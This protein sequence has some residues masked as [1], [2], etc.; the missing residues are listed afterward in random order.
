MRSLTARGPFDSLI[1]HWDLTLD[2]EDYFFILVWVVDVD[3]G[4]GLF[5][6]FN[7]LIII[8]HKVCAARYIYT[9]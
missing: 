8:L 3:V 4:G 7:L 6:S 1:F 5:L 9:K 2:P